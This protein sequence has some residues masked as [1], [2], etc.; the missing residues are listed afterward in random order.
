MQRRGEGQRG[1]E[2]EGLSGG[3]FPSQH[4]WAQALQWLHLQGPQT[5]LPQRLLPPLLQMPLDEA[6]E[7]AQHDDESPHQPEPS[8]A[9]QEGVRALGHH[10]GDEELV[11]LELPRCVK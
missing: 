6:T 10:H 8:K 7:A 11:D 2:M 5:L 9:G 3:G 4:P 1:A